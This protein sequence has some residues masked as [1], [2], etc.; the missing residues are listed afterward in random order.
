VPEGTAYLLCVSLGSRRAPLQLVGVGSSDEEYRSGHENDP[1]DSE[2]GEGE[3]EPE[4]EEND[5]HS[6]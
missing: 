4:N 1:R 3:P 2:K 6:A 5:R